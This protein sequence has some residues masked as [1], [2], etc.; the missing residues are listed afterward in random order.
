[1]T[2]MPYALAQL[3]DELEDGPTI[4]FDESVDCVMGVAADIL[5]AWAKARI[6]QLVKDFGDYAA[7][8]HATEMHATEFSAWLEEQ[9]LGVHDVLESWEELLIE[10][11]KSACVA[12]EDDAATQWAR[13]EL[14][15][16][17]RALL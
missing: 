7:E 17:L 1:M 14:A 9:Y 16:K 10:H 15:R 8:M 4:E 5:E 12:N 3:V 13:K 6:A 2:I 11:R